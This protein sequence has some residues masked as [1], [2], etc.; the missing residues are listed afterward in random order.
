MAYAYWNA[1]R[2]NEHAVFEL[3]FR[4][5]PFKGEY[6]I[7]AGLDQVVRFLRNFAFSDDDI[8]YLQSLPALAGA[9]PGF[10]QYLRQLDM[11]ENKIG[12]EGG[13]AIGATLEKNATLQQLDTCMTST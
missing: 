7:F 13:K 6:A 3:F 12:D 10:F 2:Q 9:D 8:A 11:S 4:K 5:C 1:G